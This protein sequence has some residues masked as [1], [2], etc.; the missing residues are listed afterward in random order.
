MYRS[1][2]PKLKALIGFRT[3]QTLSVVEGDMI[4][5]NKPRI[6]VGELSM[7]RPEEFEQDF[8]WRYSRIA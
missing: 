1:L 8:D 3:R 7:E 2:S 6:P 5:P 4:A